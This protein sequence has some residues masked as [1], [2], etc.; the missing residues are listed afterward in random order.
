MALL[1]YRTTLLSWC[2]LTPAEVLM[3]RKIRGHLPPAT[4]KLN[5]NWSYLEEFRKQDGEFKCKHKQDYDCRHTVRSLPPIPD[6][7]E[8]WITS[9]PQLIQGRATPAKAPR[10]Y[11][12]QTD[13]GELRRNCSRLNVVPDTPTTSNLIELNK[14]PQW[15]MTPSQTGMII[16]P[17][18]GL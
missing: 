4:E 11:T 7:S 2:N 3:G 8:V 18:D 14:P 17:P 15:I 16:R 5:P 10:S 13:S 6:E 12:V 1:T 9:G